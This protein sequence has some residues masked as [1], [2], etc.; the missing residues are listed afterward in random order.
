MPSIGREIKKKYVEGQKCP[1]THALFFFF[2]FFREKNVFLLDYKK[3][4]DKK[5]S[6]YHQ[7]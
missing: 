5:K 7:L 6:I 3:Q 4:K 1:Q 2:V